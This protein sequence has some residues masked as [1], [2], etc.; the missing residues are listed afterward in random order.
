MEAMLTI[1]QAMQIAG[2]IE[3]T[4]WHAEAL[5]FIVDMLCSIAQ[6]LHA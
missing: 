5:G 3:D 4:D 2:T 1:D 6:T